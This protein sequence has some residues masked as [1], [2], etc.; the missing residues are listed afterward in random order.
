MQVEKF[1]YTL[2]KLRK[3]LKAVF[4]SLS[5]ALLALTS[6]CVVPRRSSIDIS[7]GEEVEASTSPMPFVTTTPAESVAPT[8]EV[9]PTEEVYVPL[10]V[11]G[12]PERVSP[13]RMVD[14][15]S[16]KKG[17]EGMPLPHYAILETFEGEKIIVLDPYLVNPN[18]YASAELY[19][20]DAPG[21]GD[22]NSEGGY[23]YR[24]ALNYV[25]NLYYEDSSIDR[26]LLGDRG[27]DPRNSSA[28][29]GTNPEILRALINTRI[30][31]I[32]IVYNRS[33]S[34][35][36]FLTTDS[37]LPD[38]FYERNR[39]IVFQLF[40]GSPQNNNPFSAI[41]RYFYNYEN[42]DVW[43]NEDGAWELRLPSNR[44][45]GGIFFDPN[46]I[47]VYSGIP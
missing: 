27:T 36:F 14:G 5:L 2:E 34:E 44:P 15:P 3:L 25:L 6:A 43:T 28:F 19:S 29:N 4:L 17:P 37:S 33:T 9:T 7:Q 10:E 13:W 38:D 21:I 18:E 22:A 20:F 42:R 11:V 8:V 23:D 39:D 45:L 46:N 40:A 26:I 30:N 16:W 47:D 1:H 41:N 12:E 32:I 24:Q 35:R 31:G